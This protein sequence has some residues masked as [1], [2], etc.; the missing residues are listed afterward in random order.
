VVGADGKRSTT[1]DAV[2]ARRYRDRPAATLACY[3]YWSGM[4]LAH[5]ELY[6]RRGRAA[7]AFPTNDGLTMVYVGA[8]LGELDA[9][10]ADPEGCYLASLD[11]CGDLG[12][13]VRAGR[14]EERLRLAPDLPNVLRV[15]HGPGWALV[16]DAGAVMDPVTAQGIGNALCDA[17]R[18]A[19]AIVAGLGSAGLE[20]ALA[21]ARR[22]RDVALRPM[23]DLTV[24]LA[25]LR[26][27][28]AVDRLV[29]AA[30]RDRPDEVTRF[31]AAFSGVESL[32]RYRS[33]G[34]ALRLLATGWLSARFRRPG[35]A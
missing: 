20:A 34:N 29:M 12:E 2:G 15:P 14:R 33:P 32:R 6:Q 18:V 11:R 3:G 10:R 23:F 8:P 24:G 31:L 16:G 5:G 22:Q 4:P 27:P 17:Q 9:F 26:G 28:G 7:A 19:D 30:V 1:A 21:R 13:R 25:A 35:P